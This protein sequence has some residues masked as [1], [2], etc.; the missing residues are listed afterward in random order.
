MPVPSCAPCKAGA[1]IRTEAE[2]Q[3]ACE[4][5]RERYQARRFL[6]E[7]L[8]AERFLDP[9][10]MATLWQL[11]QDLMEA[12]GVTSPAMTMI[13]D[14]TVM[15]YANVL[16]VQGWVGDLSLVIEH[17]LFGEGS[18]KVKLRQQY[19]MHIDGFA[20]EEALRRL[21]EQLLPLCER[22]NRQFLQNLQ[23]LQQ[24]PRGSLPTMAIGRAGHVNVA[25]QQVNIQRRNGHL[26]PPVEPR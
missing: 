7:R 16:Q 26:S 12:Y 3:A 4:D 18:L 10:L 19:G 1:Q 11:R 23:A 24:P 13:V 5:A 21:R 8:G 9:Q 22:V 14:V 20:V 17:E 25:Q 6:I 15:A 2:W